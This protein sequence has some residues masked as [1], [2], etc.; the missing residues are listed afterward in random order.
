[1]RSFYSFQIIIVPSSDEDAHMVSFGSTMHTDVTGPLW[2]NYPDWSFL[3]YLPIFHRLTCL[4]VPP[5]SIFSPSNVVQ[6]HVTPPKSLLPGLWASLMIQKSFPL[7][8]RNDLILPSVHPETRLFP[9]AMNSTQ[10]HWAK[11]YSLPYINSIL[12]SSFYVYADQILISS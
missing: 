11:S 6:R 8:G 9:S 1:M 10:L 5:V 7:Y 4:S 12:K 2:T 3:V